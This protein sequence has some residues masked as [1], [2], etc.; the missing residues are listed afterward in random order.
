[1]ARQTTKEG[2]LPY[3][4]YLDQIQ[5]AGA[6]LDF[7]E[8]HATDPGIKQEVRRHFVTACVGAMESFFKETA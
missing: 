2:A 3:D 4:S 6:L 8:E 1:M 7:V 5:N